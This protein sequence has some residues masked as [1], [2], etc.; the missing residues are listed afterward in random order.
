MPEVDINERVKYL[1]EWMARTDFWADKQKAQEVI[2]E[3]R[4]LKA[5]KE[6]VTALGRSGAIMTI[7]SGA[8]GDDAEDFSRMLLEMYFKFFKP[9]GLGGPFFRKKQNRP[10]G[11]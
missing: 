9:A 4:E 3:L 8:G 2:R 5:Q 7:F 11:F 1:E 6:G 10:G